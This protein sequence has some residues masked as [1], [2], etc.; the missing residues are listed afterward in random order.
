MKKFLLALVFVFS[1][2]FV[3]HTETIC[4]DGIYYVVENGEAIVTTSIYDNPDSRIQLYE[5][6]IVIPEEVMIKGMSYKV[7]AIDDNAF[8]SASKV[9]SIVIG[10]N[11]T[12]IGYS[13]FSRCNGIKSISISGNVKTIWNYAFSNCKSLSEVYIGDGN[14][15]IGNEVFKDCE[16]LVCAK[17]PNSTISIGAKAFQSCIKLENFTI[18]ES[19]T[20][21]GEGV[22]RNCLN[23]TH[24]TIP[25]NITNIGYRAFY[26]CNKLKNIT[27]N[28]G[29]EFIGESAF[30]LCSFQEVEL[31][32]TVSTIRLK[33]FASVPL[34]TIKSKAQI[35]PEIEYS[36]FGTETIEAATLYVPFGGMTAY[37][38]AQYWGGFKNIK[39][40]QSSSLNDVFED[41]DSVYEIINGGIFIKKPNVK[42]RIY[43]IDGMLKSQ[44]NTGEVFVPLN[45][46]VYILQIDG[47]MKKVYIRN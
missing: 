6:D 1:A 40:L 20:Y 25:S 3:A 17:I 10:G 28:E 30:E 35:P 21:I 37:Q 34:N 16:N 46:G 15:L 44:N 27:I 19:L 11:V 12:K 8:S 31:P 26:N 36:T 41:I 32:S 33:A 24:I 47:R 38:N 29:V 4:V 43:S 9:T 18:P 14:E 5:G 45:Q 22:F 13:A 7:T 23:L 39:E 2:L 42:T